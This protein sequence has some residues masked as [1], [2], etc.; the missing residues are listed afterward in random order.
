MLG[1]GGTG[2]KSS[3]GTP[4]SGGMVVGGSRTGGFAALNLPACS[5]YEPWPASTPQCRSLNDCPPE[6][7][8]CLPQLPSGSSE[9]TC[10][11]SCTDPPLPHACVVDSDCGAGKVCAHQ[12]VDCCPTESCVDAPA[13]TATSCPTGSRCAGSGKCEPVPCTDGYTCPKDFV[14][15]PT[16]DRADS[17]GCAPTLCSEGYTCP[18]GFSCVPTSLEY[19]G[20]GCLPLSCTQGYVCTGGY[21]CDPARATGGLKPTGCAPP[22]CK[23]DSDCGSLK[24]CRVGDPSADDRGCIITSC[25][26]L[27]CGPNDLCRPDGKTRGCVAKTCST[28]S[29][30]DCGVCMH[31]TTQGYCA[32]RAYVC[33]NSKGG[34]PATGTGSSGAGGVSGSGGESGSH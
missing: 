21:V 2:G 3:G 18:T 4:A 29:D 34:A 24:S 11:T 13:C 1:T 7:D 22:L 19:D 8:S 20:H 30:C 33:V 12:T 31:N 32:N 5:G 14:C 25:T 16:R 17:H 6:Y 28:D 27:P 15:A 23:Q 26:E 10:A 9:P